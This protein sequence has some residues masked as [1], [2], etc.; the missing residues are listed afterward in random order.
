MLAHLRFVLSSLF[1]SRDGASSTE[2]AVAA[3]L[4]S[5]AAIIAMRTIGEELQNKLVVVA[6]GFN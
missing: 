2:Y 4:I 1:N 3:S 6:N 5:V